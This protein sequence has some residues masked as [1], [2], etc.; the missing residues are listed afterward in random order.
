MRGKP[1]ALGQHPAQLKKMPR[2]GRPRGQRAA[3]A[4]LCLCLPVFAHSQGVPLAPPGSSPTAAVVT[5]PSSQEATLLRQIQQAARHLN[6]EGVFTFQQGDAIES[7]RITHVFDGKDEKERIE[8]LDGPPREYLRR[9]DDVQCLL[10]E[11]QTIVRERQRGDRFPGLLLSESTALE[12]HYQLRVLPEPHRVAGR[13]CRAI[14][15]TAR[16]A[17]RYGY[18]LCADIDSN[19]L[20]KAQTL[21]REG[22]VLEQVT[23]TQVS[24]GQTIREQALNASWSTVGWQ[25]QDTAQQ[26]IDLAALGWRVPAPAGYLTRSQ[27][28]RVFADQ[29]VV[30][31]LVLSD[32]LAT[33]SIFIEPYRA[34]RSEYLSQGAARSG[35]VNIFGIRVADFWLTVLGEVP[36]T[37]LELLAQSIQYVPPAGSR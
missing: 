35:S 17:H 32:G 31:Q 18:K 22:T 25:L 34:Q 29:R 11:Q 20:L 13:L 37:T 30:N 23:F 21:T 8:V 33:I 3:L 7:S 12:E 27:F 5:R 19:L 14:E 1:Q 9:N 6:Y 15:I 10:P 36:A 24:I 16:D 26:V 2:V 28:A 4:G